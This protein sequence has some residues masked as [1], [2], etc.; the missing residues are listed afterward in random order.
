LTLATE[1][2]LIV[3]CGK[4]L[5]VI[6]TSSIERVLLLNKQDIVEVE[7]SQAI[8]L[9]KHPV[10]LCALSDVLELG[11][12]ATIAQNKLPIV[13]IRAGQNTAALLVDSIIGEREIVIKPLQAPLTHIPCVAGATLSG[14]G[15]IIVVL[16]LTDVMDKAIHSRKNIITTGDTEIVQKNSKPTLLLVDDS[17]TTRTFLKGILSSKGYQVEVAADGKEAWDL[18]QEKKFNLMITDVEMPNMNGFELTDRVKKSVTLRNMP[19]IIVTSLDN[20]VHKKRGTEVGADA[21]I[22][23]SDF[24]SSGL[25]QLVE[26]MI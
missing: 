24:E 23:K 12:T 15:E 7:I 18:L 1:R 8:L 9:D 25:A 5:F 21:Y 16:N 4:Q 10:S 6:A 26:Q 22:V 17:A 2:G 14:S 13:V 11:T 20:E 19:V 3:E